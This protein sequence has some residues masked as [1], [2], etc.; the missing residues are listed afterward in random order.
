MISENVEFSEAKT[1]ELQNWKDNE[2][3]EECVNKG[4]KCIS[5][6]WVCTLES[7]PEGIVRKARLVARGFE[8]PDI[9]NIEKDSPTCSK[10]ALRTIIA[11][12]V[13][14]DWEIHCLDVKTAFLQGELLKRQVYLKP[15]PEADC[16][17]EKFWKL[18]KCVYGLNAS[19]KWYGKV[20]SFVLTN[21]G[22]MTKSDPAVFCW[23]GDGKLLGVIAVHVDDFL[24]IGSADFEHKVI[25][26]LRRTFKIGKE[27]SENFIIRTNRTKFA[28]RLN[29]L[30]TRILLY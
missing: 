17:S 28:T 21:G 5:V 6:K 25:G 27:E 2:V 13:Q 12:A 20:K 29:Q 11:I 24:W 16:C 3:F 19:L 15:P 30:D 8:D 7:T 9:N 23:H 22:K 4:Q 26:Q 1:Q 18:G 14:K 10:D